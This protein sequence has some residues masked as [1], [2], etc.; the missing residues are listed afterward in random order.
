M[1]HYIFQTIK[2]VFFLGNYPTLL[3]YITNMTQNMQIEYTQNNT[4]DIN[5][6]HV[7]CATLKMPKKSRR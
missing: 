6:N 5:R 2:G 1:E 3:E 4:G 7:E